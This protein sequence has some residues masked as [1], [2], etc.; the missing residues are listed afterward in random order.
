VNPG[1]GPLRELLRVISDQVAT[2]SAALQ[3]MYDAAFVTTE[4]VCGVHRGTVVTDT[5]PLEQGRVQVLVPEVSTEA[6][7]AQ[8]SQPAGPIEEGTPVWVVYEAG[9]PGRPVVIGTRTYP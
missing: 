5:D 1:R 8:V 4:T 9:Q 2:L 6:V 7:W 3:R